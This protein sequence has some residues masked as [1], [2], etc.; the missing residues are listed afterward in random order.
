MR[1]SQY[2]GYSQSSLKGGIDKDIDV[3]IDTYT[4]YSQ[5]YG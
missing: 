3:N 5:Y 1:H 2:Y 4:S